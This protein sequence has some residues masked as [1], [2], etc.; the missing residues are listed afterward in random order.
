MFLCVSVVMR[1]SIGF[2]SYD[3]INHLR[4]KG[5][6]WLTFSVHGHLALLL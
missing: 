4:R 5:S 1:V 6:F 2:P 3:K